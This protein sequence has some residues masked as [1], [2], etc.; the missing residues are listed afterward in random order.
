MPS[1]KPAFPEH[2][3]PVHTRSRLRRFL[4]GYAART[5]VRRVVAVGNAPLAPSRE[6]AELIDSADLVFRCNSLALDEPGDEPCLGRATH[7][8]MLARGTRPTRWV[9]ENY[10]RRAYLLHETANIRRPDFPRQPPSWPDDL[11]PWPLSNRDIGI[12]LKIEVQ[13]ETMGLGAVPT[14]GTVTAYVAHELF[15]EAEFF[16]TG[17]S[18]LSDR[19]QKEWWHHSG[20][21]VPVHPTH[22]I[23]REGAL[24]QSWVDEGTATFLP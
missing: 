10:R 1:V 22:K 4:E 21:L 17:Y 15:P 7:V 16:L 8:V 19:E 9:F 20:A 3:A 24:L 12:P 13:P 5:P 14:S 11:A 18:F 6:R 23:D 2:L